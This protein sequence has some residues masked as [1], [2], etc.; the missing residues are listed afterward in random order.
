MVKI[1]MLQKD[2]EQN[3]MSVSIDAGKHKKDRTTFAFLMQ[4]ILNGLL[5]IMRRT[6]VSHPEAR[7]DIYDMVNQACGM[8]LN[9]F[10]PEYDVAPDL[11]VDAIAAM[12]EYLIERKIS[13]M[14]VSERRAAMQEAVTDLRKNTLALRTLN[15]ISVGGHPDPVGEPGERGPQSTCEVP[16]IEPGRM[17]C[18]L[19]E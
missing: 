8:M 1:T 15:T 13:E 16:D 10:D 9:A 14:P 19:N 12:E 2:P 17:A 6:A 18:D 11:T 7:H 4:M 3:T 5:T